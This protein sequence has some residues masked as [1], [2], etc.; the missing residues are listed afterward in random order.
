[1]SGWSLLP[2]SNHL[3]QQIAHANTTHRVTRLTAHEAN[4]SPIF[5]SMR[6]SAGNRSQTKRA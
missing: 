1:M 3:P 5:S 6:K 4:G 2:R